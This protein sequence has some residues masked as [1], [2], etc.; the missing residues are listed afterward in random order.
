[1]M[2]Y[3][4]TEKKYRRAIHKI[5]MHLPKVRSVIASAAGL[6]GISTSLKKAMKWGN[7]ERVTSVVSR[8]V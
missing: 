3:I 7:K 4:L 5:L 1:M 2:N 8:N 6:P